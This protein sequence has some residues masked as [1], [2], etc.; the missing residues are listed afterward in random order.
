MLM[1]NKD[2]QKEQILKGVIAVGG[3]MIFGAACA[4][5]EMRDEKMVI[6][7]DGCELQ[8]KNIN[9]LYNKLYKLEDEYFELKNKLSDK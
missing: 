6:F 8:S 7:K 2:R 1:N 5:L 9:D 3:L 4:L